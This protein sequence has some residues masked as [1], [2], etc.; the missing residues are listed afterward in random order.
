[1]GKSVHPPACIPPSQG[2]E[3][4]TTISLLVPMGARAFTG[5]RAPQVRA[6]SEGASHYVIVTGARCRPDAGEPRLACERFPLREPD[7][8]SVSFGRSAGGSLT[9]SAGASGAA[10]F[11]V[12]LLDRSNRRLFVPLASKPSRF[13]QFN[14]SRAKLINSA[15]SKLN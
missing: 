7:D 12:E 4:V 15:F 11:N 8:F 10:L 1:M 5:S 2:W 14:P 9:P 6:A 3:T 13:R